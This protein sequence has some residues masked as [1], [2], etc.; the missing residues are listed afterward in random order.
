M[1]IPLLH[2][3]ANRLGGFGRTRSAAVVSVAPVEGS[4]VEEHGLPIHGLRGGVARLGDRRGRATRAWSPAATLRGLASFPFDH[5]IEVAAS[6]RAR[7][8][9]GSTR[10]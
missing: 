6:L 3:W 1:G 8:G 10:R 9:C 2:P 7:T 5:R 4:C